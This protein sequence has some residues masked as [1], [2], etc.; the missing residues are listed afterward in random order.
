MSKKDI[1]F[2][3]I[4][5]LIVLLTMVAIFMFSSENGEKSNKTSGGVTAFV[6]KTVVKD[7]EKMT[8]QK[9]ESVMQKFT[10]IVRTLAH[11]GIF[12]VLGFFSA[13]FINTF[14]CSHLKRNVFAV[15]F[16]FAYA[17]SD[18]IHQIFVPGRAFQI[19]DIVVDTVGAVLGV[20]VFWLTL[21][22]FKRK[23]AK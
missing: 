23:F 12:S 4:S 19:S 10:E 17:L 3:I 7:F 5:A 8:L 11:F 15:V 22:A 9:K 18:E 14:K 6:V 16:G 13:N 1:A 21:T 2:K 20:I